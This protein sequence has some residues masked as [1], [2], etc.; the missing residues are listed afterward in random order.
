MNWRSFMQKLSEQ[1]EP[2]ITTLFYL[3]AFVML[4]V[5]LFNAFY[6]LMSVSGLLKIVSFLFT[7]FSG[8][9]TSAS[10]LVLAIIV[11]KIF[12][13]HSLLTKQSKEQAVEPE[14]N[15]EVYGKRLFKPME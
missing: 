3:A 10:L 8:A 2:H 7:L 1:I 5:T 6:A 4:I 9:I 12:E 11:R 15:K 13:I 14:F